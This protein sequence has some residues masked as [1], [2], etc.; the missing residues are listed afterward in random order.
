M[1][2]PDRKPLY[3][4]VGVALLRAAVAPQ[5]DAL[6]VWPDL[7]DTEACRKWL[8]LVWSRTDFTNAVRHASPV[9]ANRSDTIRSGRT[10]GDKEIRRTAAS[11]ARYLL[12]ATGRPTPFGFFAGVAPVALGRSVVARWGD[13]HRP[14]VRVSSEW[15]ADVIARLEACPE[16]LDRL[17]VVF[18]DLAIRR[19]NR[20]EV[21]QG[22][23]RASIRYTSAVHA[24]T[25]AAAVPV[26]FGVLAS[27][28][29][30]IFTEVDQA[31][32][33]A[34]LTELVQQEF[35]ITTLRAP[36]TD[37]DPLAHLVD[38]LREAGADTLPLRRIVAERS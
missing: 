38:R 17:D 18:T 35:L 26:R 22:P 9:L 6:G 28:L 21:P 29:M 8:D 11:T 31:T 2:R 30:E 12:R 19:G 14:V 3:R 20:L 34:M 13:G 37:T 24:V 4:H 27:K 15:L 1:R 10:V 33:R 16:L 7:T 36:F 5:A 23:N 25:D 32:V